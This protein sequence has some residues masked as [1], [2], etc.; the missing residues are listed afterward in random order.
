VSGGGGS[1][2]TLARNTDRPRCF[3]WDGTSQKTSKSCLRK[4]TAHRQAPLTFL[5]TRITFS[6]D[7]SSLVFAA[8]SSAL[9]AGLGDSRG[10]LRWIT[11]E[12]TIRAFRHIRSRDAR[13]ATGRHNQAVE[14]Q[15]D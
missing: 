15:D 1:L 4:F 11:V 8:I 7:S 9:H 3:S 10:P 14:H 13:N 2:A 5:S 12:G 6:H